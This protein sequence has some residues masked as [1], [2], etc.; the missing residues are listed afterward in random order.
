M[1]SR[2][3]LMS[4]VLV[5]MLVVSQQLVLAQEQQQK[6]APPLQGRGQGR[7]GMMM[8]PEERAK[9]L[10]ERLSLSDEQT[11]QVQKIFEESQ[12]KMMAMR[13]SLRGDFDAMRK[14]V[15]EVTEKTDKDIKTLLTEEQ[16]KKYDEVIKQRQQRMQQGMQQRR[17]GRQ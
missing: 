2:N 16:V 13:D 10:K 1:K 12:K 14:V 3:I 11:A 6:Q 4:L 8:S 17:Q 9:Q 5:A 7:G 15:Q